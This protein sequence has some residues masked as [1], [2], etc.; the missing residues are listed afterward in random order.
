MY[1][2]SLTNYLHFFFVIVTVDER[3]F[4]HYKNVNIFHNLVISLTH[5]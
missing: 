5:E 3:G 4:L 1:L 2:Q